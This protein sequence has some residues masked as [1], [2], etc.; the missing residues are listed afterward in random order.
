MI[1]RPPSAFV[2]GINQGIG[3]ALASAF[4]QD[5]WIVWGT[6][7]KPKEE[8][9]ALFDPRLSGGLRP[10]QL[11]LSNLDACA[12]LG[13]QVSGPLD[14]VVNS[15]AAF[16]NDAFHG[17]N[18]SAKAFLDTMAVNTVAPAV[19]ARVLKPR[20]MEGSR[21]LLV[22][23]STGNASLAG[24]TGGGM[25]SYRASKSALN[26]VVRTLAAEWR[27]VGITTVALNPG[28]V[29]TRMGGEK[30]PLRPMTAAQ[31]IV[32]FIRSAGPNL[33]GSFVSTDGS[34]LPW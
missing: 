15:A 1:D 2:S 34:P 32:S 3:H 29:K 22:M 13:A 27:D 5:G 23:M 26:Q 17:E 28:W 12:D 33:N 30:A 4:L 10:L 21:R 19:I 6:S 8:V 16:G 14:V 24:N 18:F 11:E 25:L 31:N 20:L 9:L 7:R